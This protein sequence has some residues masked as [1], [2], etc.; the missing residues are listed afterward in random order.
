M[1]SLLF[2]YFYECRSNESLESSGAKTST[3]SI[4]KRTEG[5]DASE[6]STT[7]DYITC[8]DNSKRMSMPPQA[9]VQG[10]RFSTFTK[11]TSSHISG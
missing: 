8:T 11:G 1:K 9:H 5:I 2:F 10:I 3:E 7:E 6:G 4:L